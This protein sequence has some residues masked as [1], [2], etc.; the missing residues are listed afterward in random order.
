MT[1]VSE[2]FGYDFVSRYFAPWVG[3]NED[4]VTGIG[5]LCPDALLA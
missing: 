4:P 2:N 5:A 3:V 1:S